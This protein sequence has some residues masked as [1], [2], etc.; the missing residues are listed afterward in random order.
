MN[1]IGIYKSQIKNYPDGTCIK[2]LIKNKCLHLLN[3]IARPTVTLYNGKYYFNKPF[4][5]KLTL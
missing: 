1:T 3:V 4:Q 5:L 2:N